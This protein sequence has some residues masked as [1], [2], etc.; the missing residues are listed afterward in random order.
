MSGCAEKRAVRVKKASAGQLSDVCAPPGRCRRASAPTFRAPAR[1]VRVARLPRNN[2]P[3]P[4]RPPSSLSSLPC[5]LLSTIIP[6]PG[7]PHLEESESRRPTPPDS[8]VPEFPGH[9]R[10]RRLVAFTI[11]GGGDQTA[12]RAG[13][14]SLDGRARVLSLSRS[15]RPCTGGGTRRPWRRLSSARLAVDAA[16]CCLAQVRNESGAAN[17]S[18][19]R[20]RVTRLLTMEEQG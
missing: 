3:R 8:S 10:A 9:T 14:V 19:A 4:R 18:E 11:R 17:G 20:R 6:R 7:R 5:G 2:W 12:E 15:R 16:A 1:T 13:C